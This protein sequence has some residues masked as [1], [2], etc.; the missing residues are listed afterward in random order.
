MKDLM[1]IACDA[2]RQIDLLEGVMALLESGCAD[3]STAGI[4]RTKSR[5]I[6]L[7]KREQ[8]RQ[9]HR[10]DLVHVRIKALLEKS[11]GIAA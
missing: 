7:C 2:R 6:E 9:L 1:E 11:K 10:M 4:S 3:D 5:L 8:H